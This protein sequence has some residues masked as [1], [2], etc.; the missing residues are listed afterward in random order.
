M[1][2]EMS[3]VIAHEVKNPLAGVRG[4]IQV[5]GG[6]LPEGTKDALMVK[7]ILARIDGLAELLKDLLLFARPPQP[8]RV[9]VELKR[10]AD[11][12][13]RAPGHGARGPAHRDRR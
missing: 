11:R 12:G 13:A 6:R 4:A 1:L 8:R 9:P 5:I 10:R 7:E 2:G 3:A